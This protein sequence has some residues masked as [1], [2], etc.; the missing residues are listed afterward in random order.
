MKI[1]S[2]ARSEKGDVHKENEDSFLID[3]N[4]NIFAV[5]DGVTTCPCG[6][7]ASNKA[8]KYLKELFNGDILKTTLE[9]N[10]KIFE[11]TEGICLTT[12]NCCY[13]SGNLLQII[14]VGDSSTLLIRDN[15]FVLET[16]KERIIGT[17]TVLS[18]I[19]EKEINPMYYKT[20]LKTGDLILLMTDGISD[21]LNLE[22]ILD[23][24]KSNKEIK[25]IL[26]EIFSDVERKEKL[27]D[28]D[29]TCIITKII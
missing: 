20:S 25:D 26:D 29:K 15:K 17:H 18:T 22:E 24:V 23:I 16:S 7:I 6:K 1:E 14:N 3:K 4:K 13:I 9:V 2:L 12:L 28:D 27:Y 5:A 19:G 21:I 11:E 8:V 10:K